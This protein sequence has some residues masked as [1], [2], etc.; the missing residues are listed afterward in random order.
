[1]EEERAKHYNMKFEQLLAYQGMT[2]DQY[3]EYVSETAKF[4]VTKELVLSEIIKTE[5]I[6]LT[7]EDYENGYQKLADA[8]ERPMDEIKEK[9]PRDTVYQYFTL[10][11]TVDL[12][13]EKAVIKEEK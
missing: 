6:E 9:F 7:D 2:L 11:K 12:L 3:R 13:K 4:E 10:N 5:K 8:Y 1:M